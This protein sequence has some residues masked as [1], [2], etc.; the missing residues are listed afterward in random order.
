M[1][2]N[3]NSLFQQS[4]VTCFLTGDALFNLSISYKV[5]GDWHMAILCATQALRVRQTTLPLSHPNVAA[6]H[7]W[8]RDLKEGSVLDSAMQ[9]IDPKLRSSVVLRNAQR[10]VRER[11]S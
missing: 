7:R 5:N 1:K 8:I 10:Q 9:L 2:T 11:L 3:V 6:V 4:I